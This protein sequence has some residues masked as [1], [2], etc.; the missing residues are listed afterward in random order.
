VPEIEK[1][2]TYMLRFARHGF[3]RYIGHL[4]WIRIVQ[5]ALD[6]SGLP[7][8]YT[9]GYTPKAKLKYSP[10]LPVG[11][12]SDCEL[13]LLHLSKR[14]TAETLMQSLNNSMPY[15]MNITGA[16]H[17]YHPLAKNPFQSINGALYEMLFHGRLTEEMKNR[18]LDVFNN[19]DG[20]NGEIIEQSNLIVKVVNDDLFLMETGNRIEYAA[21]LEE[22]QTF[23]PVKF[24]MALKNHLA[25]EYMP[26]GKKLSFLKIEG[27]GA[28]KLFQF[29]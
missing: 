21:R 25:L 11:L 18:I 9:E 17:L 22:K 19:K 20:S 24:A 2:F 15:G 28:R 26:E 14:L 8:V 27:K 16:I 5:T 13:V 23:H 1:Q 3:S 6:R 12:E 7:L 29:D 4:D 10:P